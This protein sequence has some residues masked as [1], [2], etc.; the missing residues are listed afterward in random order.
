MKKIF[1]IVTVIILM[2]PAF[3]KDLLIPAFVNENGYFSGTLFD[4]SK[5][6]E[7]EKDII[8]TIKNNRR[9][10]NDGVE[11]SLIRPQKYNPIKK[12]QDSAYANIGPREKPKDLNPNVQ[13][14]PLVVIE[15]IFNNPSVFLQSSLACPV[16][17]SLK[18]K[19]PMQP[20][21]FN[22]SN[23]ARRKT[24]SPDVAEGHIIYVKARVRDI[25]CV[26]IQGA[27][28]K[29]WQA[30]SFGGFNHDLKNTDP[31]YD[32][33]FVGTATAISDN[34][35]ALSFITILPG[36]VSLQYAPNIDL[37]VTHNSFPNLSTKYFFPENRFNQ[38]DGR[39]MSLDPVGRELL[40]GI[41]LPVNPNNLAEGYYYLIDIVLNGVSRFRN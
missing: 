16:T 19:D 25:N 29:L 15:D 31:N 11:I 35:G 38:D 26:P 8:E 22:T 4:Y 9:S 6:S 18:E 39:F 1:L 20:T 27:V 24:K 17:P 5:L 41:L 3:A 34:T 37:V 36:R 21:N 14:K 10:R 28:V 23:N 7:E 32:S 33:D 13:P 40:T 2:Q 30:N 12:D